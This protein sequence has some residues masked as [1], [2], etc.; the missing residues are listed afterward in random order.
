M[1]ITD[2]TTTTLLPIGTKQNRMLP[3][4]LFRR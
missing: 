2:L 4:R 3:F 1:R